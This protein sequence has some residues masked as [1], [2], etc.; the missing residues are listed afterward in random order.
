MGTATSADLYCGKNPIELSVVE[1]AF[2]WTTW[3]LI[4][5]GLERNHLIPGMFIYDEGFEVHQ[6]N[7]VDPADCEGA[8]RG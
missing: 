7:P 6:M 8:I 3:K 1:N 4:Q 2:G 5:G